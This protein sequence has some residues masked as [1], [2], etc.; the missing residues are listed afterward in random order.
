MDNVSLIMCHAMHRKNSF[1]QTSNFDEEVVFCLEQQMIPAWERHGMNHLA[2]TEETLREFRNQPVPEQVKI[3]EK[4]RRGKRVVKRQQVQGVSGIIETWSDDDQ[5]SVRFPL[6]TYVRSGRADFRIADY[7]VQCP[8]EHFLLFRPGI[9]FPAG[10]GPYLESPRRDKQC[11]VWSFFSTGISHYVALSMSASDGDDHFNS[12]HYYIVSES[13]V[14][15]LFHFAADELLA[16]NRDDGDAAFMLLNAFLRLFLR[17]IKTN[18]FHDRGLVPASTPHATHDA[19][20]VDSAIQI[21]RQYIARNLNHSLTIDSVARAV[22]LS[23]T[24]FIRQF[25][26]ETGQTFHEYLTDC[27][28]EEAKHWLLR[29]DCSIEVVCQF[30]GLKST[31]FHELFLGHFKMT[32]LEFRKKHRSVRKRNFSTENEVTTRPKP[33]ITKLSTLPGRVL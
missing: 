20:Y 23:R 21:A 18:R 24:E 9:A 13:K 29:K 4:K 22:F 14:S 12:G 11:E 16:K 32:P 17:E 10:A 30:V 3:W 25:R 26:E 1:S 27:R 31:R 33:D 6:L 19:T 2:V 15:Q 7:V 28:L 5:H 8:S